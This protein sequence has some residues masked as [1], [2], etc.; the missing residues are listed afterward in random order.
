M[1]ENGAFQSI[2]CLSSRIGFYRAIKYSTATKNL[3][4][5]VLTHVLSAVG[6]ISSLVREGDLYFIYRSRKK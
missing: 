1:A 2:I 5:S 4:G 3:K 6:V